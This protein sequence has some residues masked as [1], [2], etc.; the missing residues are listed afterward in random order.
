MFAHELAAGSDVVQ[1]VAPNVV[2]ACLR[3]LRRAPLSFAIS[4]EKARSEMIIA[5]VPMEVRPQR[6]ERP[7]CIARDVE[8]IV[9]ILTATMS[10]QGAV[11]K[12]GS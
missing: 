6:R 8:R 4:T 7:E 5:P 10:G 3:L 9:G 12:R 11:G 2:L 1:G